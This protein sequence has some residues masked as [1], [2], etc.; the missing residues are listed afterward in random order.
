MSLLSWLPSADNAQIYALFSFLLKSCV[1]VQY[2][3]Y[4]L[5]NNSCLRNYYLICTICIFQFGPAYNAPIEVI[6]PTG[7][8][9]LYPCHVLHLLPFHKWPGTQFFTCY[10]TILFR[11]AAHYIAAVSRANVVGDQKIGL[12]DL[13][14]CEINLSNPLGKWALKTTDSIKAW[15]KHRLNILTTRH[16]DG[17]PM[18]EFTPVTIWYIHPP[19]HGNP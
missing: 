4:K 15:T 6:L 16:V 7:C 1:P 9:E 12:I 18:S 17:T 11:L 13:C 3:S 2:F 19:H 8:N 5:S 14:A 10:Q